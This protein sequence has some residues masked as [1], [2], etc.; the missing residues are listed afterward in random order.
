MQPPGG[1]QRLCIHT[2]PTG[3]GRGAVLHAHAFGEEMNKSRRMC[4]LGARAMATA[5]F[6]VLQIDLLGCGDSSA[7]FGEATWSDWVDDLA[8]GVQWLRDRYRDV[9]LWLWGHRAGAL[10]C[11]AL[12]GR[13]P[14]ANLLLW[15][16]VLQGKAVTQ[17]MLRLKS[18]ANWAAGDGG[19]AAA[20][21]AKADLEAGKT[22]EIAGYDLTPTMAAAIDAATLVPVKADH[23]Q[24]FVWL[25]VAGSDEQISL[26]PSAQAQLPRWRS[27][28][29][30]IQAKAVSG[31]MFWQTAEIEVSPALTEATASLL[32]QPQAAME[33]DPA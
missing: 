31:P 15:N 27:H 21:A 16:P 30:N 29:W 26:S 5:G 6:A 33:L 1:G 32:T 22:V 19:K 13:Y 17:Q 18:A 14:M 28:G 3:T 4:A 9:P 7:E 2:P 8:F 12:L 20:A 23:R 25:E 10:L 24:R 11:S